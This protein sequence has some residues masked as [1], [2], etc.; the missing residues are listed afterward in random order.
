MANHK[1]SEKRARQDIQR[2]AINRAR[3]SAVHTL[4]KAVETAIASGDAANA[5][6]ALRKA[7]S[8]MAKTASKGSLRKKTVAR[9]T[10]RLAQRVK[11]VATKK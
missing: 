4:V 7:E 11:A 1:S 6:T 2:N 3:R 5:L 9:K 10:S 8:A